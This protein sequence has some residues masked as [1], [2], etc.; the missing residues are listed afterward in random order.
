MNR[1]EISVTDN[2]PGIPADEVPN[3]FSKFYRGKS[4]AT[5]VA[6][7]GLGLAI[8]KGLV[9]L[10]GGTIEVDSTVGKGTTMSIALPSG[11]AT[12]GPGR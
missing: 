7:A 5:E 12:S 1:V 8:A 9:E 4:V 6:G 3:I 10:H 2:G 11:R